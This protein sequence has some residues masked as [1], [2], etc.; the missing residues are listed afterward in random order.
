LFIQE[1]M[2][3]NGSEH[4]IKARAC[5]L[6]LDE[7]RRRRPA[8]MRYRTLSIGVGE[9]EGL[10]L[11]DYGHCNFASRKHAEIYFDQYAQVGNSLAR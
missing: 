11:S 2:G 3:G 10:N 7:R 8:L 1:G 4:E 5:L 6:P 9:G